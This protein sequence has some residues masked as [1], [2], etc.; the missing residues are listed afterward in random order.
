MNTREREVMDALANAL[1]VL[2]RFAEVGVSRG[3]AFFQRGQRILRTFTLGD[4]LSEPRDACRLA[5]LVSN[6]RDIVLHPGYRTVLLEIALLDDEGGDLAG[7]ECAHLF[8][9]VRQIRRMN[10]SL[11]VDTPP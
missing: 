2:K 6:Q 5:G 7:D 8:E 9:G 10:Q 3:P 1:T 4:V 11:E